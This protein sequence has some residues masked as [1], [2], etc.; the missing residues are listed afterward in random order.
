MAIRVQCTNPSCGEVFVRSDEYIGTKT[1]CPVCNQVVEVTPTQNYSRL[2]AAPSVTSKPSGLNR[3]FAI[4]TGVSSVAA[5]TLLIF[6][7]VSYGRSADL[8][9]QLTKQQKDLQA[10]AA[11]SKKLKAA[12]QKLAGSVHGYEKK[13]AHLTSQARVDSAQR[14][15]LSESLQSLRAS[16]KDQ[17]QYIEGQEKRWKS[18]SVSLKKEL[19]ERTA[20]WE[21]VLRNKSKSSSQRETLLAK[22][23]GNLKKEILRKDKSW[24]TKM[25]REKAK[26]RQ[27]ETSMKALIEASKT[28]NSSRAPTRS[29]RRHRRRRARSQIGIY[30]SSPLYSYVPYGYSGYSTALYPSYLYPNVVYGHDYYGHDYAGYGGSHYGSYSGLHDT[31]II[32]YGGHGSSYIGYGGHRSCLGYGGHIGHGTS[33]GLSVHLN[34]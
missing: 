13:L 23:V 22:Q 30:T 17:E 28:S 4:A 7:T 24:A 11:E 2:S 26:S 6:L 33:V 27:Y 3:L 31:S 29:R 1:R 12:Q 25:R 9:K 14:K 8:Q 32:G 21:T 18:E 5:A 20:N 16:I 19:A 15:V 34:R 10:A